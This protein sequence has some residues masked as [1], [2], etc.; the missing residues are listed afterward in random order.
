MNQEQRQIKAAKEGDL[1]ALNDLIQ[2]YYLEI[3][4]YCF[5]HIKNKEQ[6]EDI[7]QET[8][9]KAIRFLNAYKN[10]GTFRAFLYKIALNACID[11]QKK[12]TEM[13]DEHIPEIFFEESG[14]KQSE[15]TLDFEKFL[16][17]LNDRQK[18]LV[19]LR[20]GQDLSFR[21][22]AEVTGSKLRTVQTEIRRSLKKIEKHTGKEP[23]S[24]E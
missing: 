10:N 22:I 4:K 9:Y 20:F 14:F 1:S 15:D 13:L 11:H 3:Y 2:S 6:A 5:W 19:I 21:E 18:E 23:R 8:F 24:H 7:T 17:P 16:I 12:K